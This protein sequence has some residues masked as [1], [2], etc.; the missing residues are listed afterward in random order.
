MSAAAKPESTAVARR[1]QL[2]PEQQSIIEARKAHGLMVQ[3]IRGTIWAKEFDHDTIRAVAAWSRE[4][5]VDPVTELDVLGGRIYINARYY[6]RKLG[7]LIAAGQIEYAR[8]EWVHVD[9]RLEK[10]ADLGDEE[11]RAESRRRLMLRVEHNLPDDAD[12]AC[13]YRIKHRAMA[14]EVTGAKAHV[15]GKKRTLKKRDGT[16]TFT[17]DADPVGDA[18]PMETIETRALR[19][20]MLKLKEALPDMHV[21][22]SRD[23]DSIDLGK[24]VAAE[25]TAIADDKAAHAPRRLAPITT[26]YDIPVATEPAKVPL[27]VVESEETEEDVRRF[28]Q[29]L[30]ERESTGE[31]AL[32]DS[33][34]TTRNALREG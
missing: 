11:A 9:P 26:E 16:G 24:V 13:I 27:R 31:L 17:V 6:E 33:R 28:E 32:D 10:L 4:N 30:V 20:A 3:Q 29:E 2:S 15:P 23:D 8:G 5:D 14:E 19:R 12:A 22:S 21:A 34:P 7:G 1:P 25:V 18:A